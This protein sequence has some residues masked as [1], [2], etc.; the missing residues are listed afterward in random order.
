MSPPSSDDPSELGEEILQA[1]A[2]NLTPAD[3]SEQQ[4]NSLRA[5]V[6]EG[7]RNAAPPNTETIRGDTLPWHEVFP[8]VWVKVLKVEADWQVSLIRF[9]PGGVIPAHPHRKDE[10]CMVI[11]GEVCVAGSHL[12]RAG[13]FHFARAG[14]VHP[15]MAS[16]TGALVMLRSEIHEH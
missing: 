5:R 16:H 11:E 3:L 14:S 4:R 8:K 9:E 13:D 6:L 7:T 1:L 10:E 12:V 15:E 2:E